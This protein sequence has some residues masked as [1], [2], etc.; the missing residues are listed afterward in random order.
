[1]YSRQFNSHHFPEVEFQWQHTFA[2]RRNLAV[3]TH[4]KQVPPYT[5]CKKIKKLLIDLLELR[6][7]G[8]ISV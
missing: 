7:G 5:I 4:M 8:Y 1:M 2:L 3:F 6:Q